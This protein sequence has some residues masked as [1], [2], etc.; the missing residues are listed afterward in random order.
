MNNH[1]HRYLAYAKVYGRG[2]FPLDM[3]RYDNCVPATQNDVCLMQRTFLSQR[4]MVG[5]NEEWEICVKRILLEPNR[6]N[7]ACFTIGRW[8]SFQCDIIEVASPNDK[9]YREV[10]KL[11][12]HLKN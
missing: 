1:D 6:G 2:Q 10:R 12:L 7:K 3:L 5:S 11:Y 9:P 8:N 4:G